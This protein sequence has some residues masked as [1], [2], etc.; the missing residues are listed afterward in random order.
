ME[1]DEGENSIHTVKRNH[2]K[3]VYPQIHTTLIPEILKK[4]KHL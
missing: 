1:M 2:E 3:N 4:E